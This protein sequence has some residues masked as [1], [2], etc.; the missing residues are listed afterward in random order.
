[1]WLQQ[2]EVK[3]NST[4]TQIKQTPLNF[5]LSLLELSCKKTDHDTA[6]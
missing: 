4:G 3:A 5:Q 2:G 6:S 1:M